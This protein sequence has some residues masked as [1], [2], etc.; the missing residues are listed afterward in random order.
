MTSEV[1]IGLAALI[2]NM[3]VIAVG[4][5]VL[6]GTVSALSTR[7]QALETEIGSL[8]ELKV[9]VAEVKTTVTF[10]HEQFKELNSSIR[11]LRQP[12]DYEPTSPPRVKRRGLEE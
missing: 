7:V 2:L 12:A 11:W 1:V 6:K 8:G 4:Y 3:L 5:G 10:M 9:T